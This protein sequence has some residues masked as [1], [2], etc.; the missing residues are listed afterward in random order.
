MSA[1]ALDYAYRYAFASEVAKE[2]RGARLRLATFGGAE[3]HPN[4]FQGR[5]VRPRQTADLLRGMMEVVHA[6]YHVPAAMLSRI[7]AAADPVVTC[8]DD[9]L[10]FE[11]FSGCCSLYTTAA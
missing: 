2:S 5:L 3:E 11:G 8:S 9:R 1:I 6:R 4:F 10:R 7:L